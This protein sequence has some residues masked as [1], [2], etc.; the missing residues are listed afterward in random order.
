[1][2]A[3]R[4]NK[5]GRIVLTPKEYD[6]I[7]NAKD[8]P[9]SFSGTPEGFIIRRRARR[10]KQSGKSQCLPEGSAARRFYKKR[11]GSGWKKMPAD[12]P[13]LINPKQWR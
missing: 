12:F 1:M 11:G 13:T 10:L 4:R 6:S 8:P 9:L 2:N 3:R 7:K 5:E